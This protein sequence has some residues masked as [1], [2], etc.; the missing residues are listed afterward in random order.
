MPR[1][2]KNDVSNALAKAAQNIKDA[3]GP[4]GIASRSD[5]TDKLA[6]IESRTERDLTDMFFRFTD[7]RDHAAGARITAPDV[8]R[9]FEYAKE[10]LLKSYDVNN[11]GYSASEIAKMSRTGQLAVRLAAE[12]KGVEVPRPSRDTKLAKEITRAAEKAS[13]MSESDSR[14]E[15][16]SVAFP[17]SRAITGENV[18]AAFAPV[19]ASHYDEQDGSIAGYTFEPPTDGMAALA[20]WSIPEDATDPFYVE[21]ASGWR[22]LKKVFEDNLTEVQM[23]R[24]GARDETNPSEM[25]VDDGSY[26]YLLIGRTADGKLAGVQFESVE[27]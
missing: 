20:E 12:L 15:F 21:M 10:K 9:S 19:I 25:G 14:P 1:I 23:F 8:D 6:S 7:H 18:M 13:Y 24:I 22:E 26:L 27:T 17:T 4:D 5:L 16:V 3:A 2:A 11:N